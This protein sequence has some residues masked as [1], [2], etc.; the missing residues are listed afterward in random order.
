MFQIIINKFEKMDLKRFKD[1]KALIEYSNDLND[2][3]QGHQIVQISRE[4]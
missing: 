2:L 1:P 3:I 4:H